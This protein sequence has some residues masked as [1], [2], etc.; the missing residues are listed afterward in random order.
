MEKYK[1]IFLQ[2]P[3]QNQQKAYLSIFLASFLNLSI[4]KCNMTLH[5]NK[6]IYI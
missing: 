5:N 1:Y 6:N 2:P 4:K 3:Y